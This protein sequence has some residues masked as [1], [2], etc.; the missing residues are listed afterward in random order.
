MDHAHEGTAMGPVRARPHPV[1][2]AGTAGWVA[3][4]A[5]ATALVIRHNELQPATNWVVVG[6]GALAAVAGTVGPVVRWLRT[7][8]ELDALV[9][10]CTTGVVWRSTLE[11]PLDEAREMSIEQSYVGRQLG[12]GHL[13]IVDGD[14]TTH[15]MPPIGDVAAWRAAL[16]RRDRRASSRRS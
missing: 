14:G 1:Y 16:S 4:V 8:T 9:V 11:V 15:V 7:S 2:F 13:R 6:W 12:Y 5:F 3:F 10:R